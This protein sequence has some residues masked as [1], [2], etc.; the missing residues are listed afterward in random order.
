MRGAAEAE[1]GKYMKRFL[2]GGLLSLFLLLLLFSGLTVHTLV[3]SQANGR[4]INYV[5]I[6]RGATQRLVKLELAGQRSDALVEYLDGI[7]HEL[8]GGEGTYGLPAPRDAAYRRDLA[9]LGLMWGEIKAEI[10][11]YRSG[12][13]GAAA[14]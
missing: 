7:L 1:E 9:Q 6:V 8:E 12:D 4:L 10:G 14:L 2:K 5:G 11:A 13:G 3:Q